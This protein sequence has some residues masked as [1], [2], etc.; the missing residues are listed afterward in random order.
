V[1]FLDPEGFIPIGAMT[2]AQGDPGLGKSTWTFW[3]AAR[4]TREGRMFS[5][6][7]WKTRGARSSS[8]GF[9]LRVPIWNKSV[10]FNVTIIPASQSPSQTTDDIR[11]LEALVEDTETRLLIVDPFMGHM[12]A[13]STPTTTKTSAKP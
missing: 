13:T 8:R 2:L 10:S 1:E 11:S 4:V 12:S 3:Q 6:H 9:A 7:H 5:F